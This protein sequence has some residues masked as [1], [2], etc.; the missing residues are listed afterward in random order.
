[1]PHVARGDDRRHK[2]IGRIP[3]YH[4]A[5]LATLAV[6]GHEARRSGYEPLLH[7]YPRV[8]WNDA[9]ALA[10]AIEAADPS[11]VSA[12]IAEPVIGAKSGYQLLMEQ[13]M[14][15]IKLEG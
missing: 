13:A 9:D 8:P 12:F 4:G 2:V 1:M 14:K 11:T 15:R 5:T 6:G 10:G 3:S 7:E